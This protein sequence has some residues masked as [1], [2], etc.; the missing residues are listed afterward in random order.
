MST[1][2]RRPQL[3]VLL[4]T[5]ALLSVQSHAFLMPVRRISQQCINQ[6]LPSTVVLHMSDNQTPPEEEDDFLD[7][8]FFDPSKVKEGSP[9]KWFAD[10][11]ENDY[12]TAEALYASFFISALVIVSQELF[13]FQIHGDHYVPFKTGGSLW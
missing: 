5:W 2:T 1:Q 4:C 13:R 8:Q 12:A 3:L 6:R 9:L 11:V 7:R 10:L